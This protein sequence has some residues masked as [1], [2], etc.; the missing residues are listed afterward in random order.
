MRVFQVF[1]H[2]EAVERNLFVTQ[3]AGVVHIYKPSISILLLQFIVI[4]NSS[5]ERR[6]GGGEGEYSAQD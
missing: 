2:G 5:L 6:R 3:L 1:T 4:K